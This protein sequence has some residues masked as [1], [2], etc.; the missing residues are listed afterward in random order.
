MSS[1]HPK[2]DVLQTLI[3]EMNNN[4]L[5]G[6]MLTIETPDGNIWTGTS[7]K[8]DLSSNDSLEPCNVSKF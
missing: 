1:N 7:G 8:V 2:S 4:G 3:D 6:V 5:T